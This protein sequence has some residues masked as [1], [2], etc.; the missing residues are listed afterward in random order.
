MIRVIIAHYRGNLN[1]IR[2]ECCI[3]RL[4]VLATAVLASLENLRLLGVYAPSN[5]LPD[6]RGHDAG[7]PKLWASDDASSNGAPKSPHVITQPGVKRVVTTS[8]T[9]MSVEAK[10]IAVPAVQLLWY[11]VESFATEP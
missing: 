11:L 1:I 7:Q 3:Q 9:R 8:K 2:K 6:R 5:A 10:P 4:V